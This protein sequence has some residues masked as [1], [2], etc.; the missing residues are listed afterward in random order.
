MSEPKHL[1]TRHVYDSIVIGPGLGASVCAALLSLRG[2]RVLHVPH[3]SLTYTERDFVF[4][5]SNLLMPRPLSGGTGPF[6]AALT[7]LGLTQSVQKI[8][9]TVQVQVLE[10]NN[11][12]DVLPLG[13][14]S[15]GI[16]N[17][18]SSA[19][20]AKDIG[21]SFLESQPFPPM[22]FIERFK[23]RGVEKRFTE[24]NTGA[25]FGQTPLLQLMPFLVPVASPNNWSVARALG[26]FIEAPIGATAGL[27]ESTTLIRNRARE[28]GADVLS[29]NEKIVGVLIE[30]RK[31][32]G[33]RIGETSYRAP[34]LV[35]G[36]RSGALLQL[37]ESSKQSV[38][39]KKQPAL[40]ASTGILHVHAVLPS[41]ALPPGLGPL[42]LVPQSPV[43]AVLMQLTDTE[44]IAKKTSHKRLSL[45]VVAPLSLQSAGD[46]A[47]KKYIDAVWKALDGV[48]PFTRQHVLVES[49]P[50]L[51]ES[52]EIDEL[53]QLDEVSL[54]GVVGHQAQA[55]FGLLGV[56]NE[57]YPGLA[58]E[59]EALSA[60]RAVDVIVKHFQ[61][62]NSL[63]KRS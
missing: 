1:A 46:P 54:F 36:L 41:R 56:S 10:R 25:P 35:N 50:W 57:Q 40:R 5:C 53:Y 61:K 24:W 38:V 43:G 22:G 14:P 48:I 58:F 12:A 9:P 45:S 37:I 21:N 6:D 18:L 17:L 47:I 3:Q 19:S 20:T 59:G 8:W 11:F 63:K 32:T 29:A 49:S 44:S 42:A 33:I 27:D 2:L 62:T 26:R 39:I 4:P 7:T 60:R 51:R 52:A 13:A 16:A 23:F 15:P 55:P 28:L 34:F 31:A 30:G